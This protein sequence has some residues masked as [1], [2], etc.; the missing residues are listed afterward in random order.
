MSQENAGDALPVPVVRI[1]LRFRREGSIGCEDSEK[2][3]LL[4]LTQA[5]PHGAR[6]LELP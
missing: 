1:L 6:W 2:L 5:G 3:V 4:G